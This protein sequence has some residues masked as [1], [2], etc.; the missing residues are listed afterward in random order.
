MPRKAIRSQPALMRVTK[1]QGKR[2]KFAAKQPGQEELEEQKGQIQ[3]SRIFSDSQFFA[4]IGIPPD[5]LTDFTQKGADTIMVLKD[6]L[7]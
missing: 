7:D 4:S 1:V 3:R 5:K 6:E 2:G